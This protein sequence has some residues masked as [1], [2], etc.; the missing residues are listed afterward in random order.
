M[1]GSVIP[2]G[3]RLGRRCRTNF[4]RYRTTTRVQKTV[5]VLA[6]ARLYGGTRPPLVTAPWL[7]FSAARI[8]PAQ[9]STPRAPKAE[10][11]AVVL[12][13]VPPSACG[14]GV[15]RRGMR[16]TLKR[17]QTRP[18]HGNHQGP[19]N[20]VPAEVVVQPGDDGHMD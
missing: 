20:G 13:P 8:S 2:S 11:G 10:T 19:R 17:R 16:K 18:Y 6:Y 12:A 9:V 5:F 1:R 15:T 14:P 4:Q 7:P 3:G